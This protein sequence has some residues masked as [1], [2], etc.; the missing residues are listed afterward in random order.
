MNKE[1]THN[2]CVG[3]ASAPK[4]EQAGQV[5][6]HVFVFSTF[7]RSAFTFGFHLGSRQS[8]GFH[9]YQWLENCSHFEKIPNNKKNNAELH[10]TSY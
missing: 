6:R 8:C 5:D 3:K 9:L 4:G 10:E 2:V 1:S 7:V